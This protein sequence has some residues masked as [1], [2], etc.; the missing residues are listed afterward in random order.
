MAVE[1][2]TNC[3]YKAYIIKYYYVKLT[4]LCFTFSTKKYIMF[5]LSLI[6]FLEIGGSVLNYET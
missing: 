1:I 6:Y 4:Q 2:V 3:Y 5:S